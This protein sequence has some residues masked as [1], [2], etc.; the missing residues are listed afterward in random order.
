VEKVKLLADS[1]EKEY[2]VKTFSMK[3]DLTQASQVEEFMKM[4]Y[5]TF[6]HIEILINNAAISG[7][8]IL[9]NLQQDITTVNLERVGVPMLGFADIRTYKIEDKK[10]NTFTYDDI[11]PSLA[12]LQTQYKDIISTNYTITQ[13]ITDE[14]AKYMK[15][16]SYGRII[17]LSSIYGLRDENRL[18]KERYDIGRNFF[19]RVPMDLTRPEMYEYYASKRVEISQTMENAKKYGKNNITVNAIAP[20]L[21]Q[22]GKDLPTEMKEYLQHNQMIEMQIKPEN[23]MPAIL[24]LLSPMSAAITGT[25]IPIDGGWNAREVGSK[26]K[27]TSK[28]LKY[29]SGP[30]IIEKLKSIGYTLIYGNYITAAL[31]RVS[32]AKE[33]EDKVEDEK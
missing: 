8:S 20:S 2:G 14:A 18:I 4:T 23:L 26:M 6:G 10:N 7:S 24:S 27:P 19:L 13:T 12:P 32:A 33:F 29:L 30:R 17:N 21:V 31:D 15:E 25:I 5:Q 1:I 11:R 22:V 28:Q 3:V 9:N 16:S